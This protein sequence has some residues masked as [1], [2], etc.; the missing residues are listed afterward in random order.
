MPPPASSGPSLGSTDAGGAKPYD[1]VQFCAKCNVSEEVP[2]KSFVRCSVCAAVWHAPCAGTPIAR[3]VLEHDFYRQWWKCHTCEQAFGQQLVPPP[4]PPSQ[5]RYAA[6]AAP[7]APKP[8]PYAY[9]DAPPYATARDFA[10]PRTTSTESH[11]AREPRPGDYFKHAYDP[12]KRDYASPRPAPLKHEDYT[13]PAYAGREYYGA[14]AP[15]R[16]YAPAYPSPQPPDDRRPEAWR[17][18][19]PQPG[20]RD[21]PLAPLAPPL[22]APA[23]PLAPLAPPLAAPAAPLAPLAAGPSLAPAGLGPALAGGLPA[24]LAADPAHTNPHWRHLNLPLPDY[25]RDD[26]RSPAPEAKDLSLYLSSPLAAA[27]TAAD[28]APDARLAAPADV[29]G[30]RRPAYAAPAP[31]LSY[32]S[33]ASSHTSS[34]SSSSSPT[35]SVSLTEAPSAEPAPSSESEFYGRGVKHE[36]ARDRAD[37]A[38]Q[39]ADKACHSC[40][41]SS[42]ILFE[43]IKLKKELAVKQMQWEAYFAEDHAEKAALTAELERVRAEMRRQAD[44]HAAEARDLAAQVRAQAALVDSLQARLESRPQTPLRESAPPSPAPAAYRL[45]SVSVYKDLDFSLASPFAAPA[46]PRPAS[47]A[48]S[49]RKR[50]AAAG[51]AVGRE[52]RLGRRDPRPVADPFG[53]AAA[54]A[55]PVVRGAVLAFAAG[56]GRAFKVGRKV[57]G[58]LL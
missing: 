25:R 56:R 49:R 18:M 42:E 57:R 33:S 36:P 5:A 35:S 10:R 7:D 31:A 23:A 29:A 13:T 51:P 22:A 1:R 32:S 4:R 2:A 38:R 50:R 27:E 37:R 19:L 48:S 46:A 16:R 52:G 15:D 47:R 12:N 20:R 44:R 58:E 39:P 24:P 6:Y 41:I 8:K 40:G 21:T 26:A 53:L 43:R 55:V 11:F 3:E 45:E 14:D 28:R 54:D 9:P 34:H 17:Y 30:P